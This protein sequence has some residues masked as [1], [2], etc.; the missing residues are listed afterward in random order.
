SAAQNTPAPTGP[1]RTHGAAIAATVVSLPA[2]KIPGGL[3]TAMPGASPNQS[4]QITPRPVAATPPPQAVS[5]TPA[6][7][8]KPAAGGNLRE[9]LWFKKGDVDQMVADARARV[10]AARAKGIAVPDPDE[11]VADAVAA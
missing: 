8:P 4:G 1:R 6:P 7:T 11:A 10:E 2:A 3:S 9:T 5:A